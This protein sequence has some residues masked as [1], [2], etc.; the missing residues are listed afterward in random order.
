VSV[1]DSEVPL[2]SLES[3]RV[4]AQRFSGS[5]A[6]G[7]GIQTIEKAK[8]TSLVAIDFDLQFNETMLTSVIHTK[9]N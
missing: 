2:A 6:L 1:L 3:K 8:Q 5:D 7:S 4:G 9:R